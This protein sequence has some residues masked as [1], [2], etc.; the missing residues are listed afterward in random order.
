MLSI[1]EFTILSKQNP[2]H[3]QKISFSIVVISLNIKDKKHL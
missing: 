1:D 2:Y 3:F